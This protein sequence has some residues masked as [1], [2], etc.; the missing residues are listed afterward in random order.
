MSARQPWAT[1]ALEVQLRTAGPDDRARIARFLA[2]MDRDGLYQRHF[3]QGEAPNQAL[4]GRLDRLDQ[5]S[6]VAVLAVGRDGEV[7]G[8]AEYVAEQGAAEFAF[9]VSPEWRGRGI[10]RRLLLALLDIAGDAGLRELRGMI[11]A[12]N[13]RALQLVLGQGFRVARGDDATVVIVSRY[14]TLDR[15]AA[16]PRSVARNPLSV[17]FHDADRTPL[18]RRPGSRTP[19]RAGG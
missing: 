2:A 14:L 1:G 19:L 9:M 17:I 16:A 12:S 3:Q 10:G 5:A 11:Q 4:L 15:E 8:H 6:C 13:R 18:Y 7:L